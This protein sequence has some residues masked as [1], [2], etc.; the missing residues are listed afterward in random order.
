MAQAAQPAAAPP[1]FSVIG[2][3][4]G[5]GKTTLLNR[6]LAEPRA[7]RC[8]VLVNDFG[9]IAVD[10]ALIDARG[11]ET[12]AMQNG[13]ICC[14]I[15]GDLARAI[16]AALDLAPAHIVVEASGVAHPGR[17][18]AVARVSPELRPGRV[19][20]LADAGALR[21]QLND[22]WIADT[23]AAQL[24]AAD[25][26]LVSK[27][28][29]QP[30]REQA[31]VIDQ[32]A[33]DHP[34]AALSTTDEVQWADLLA[35]VDAD[36]CA[37]AAPAD[38]DSDSPDAPATATA[39][40]PDSHSPDMATD[41][42]APDSHTTAANIDAVPH[43]RFVARTLRADAPIDLRRLAAYLKSH[44]DIYR[45]K[46]WAIDPAD[47]K[48]KLLQAAGPRLAI[49]PYPAGNTVATTDTT[50]TGATGTTAATGNAGDGDADG[51]SG[52]GVGVG[53]DGVGDRVGVGGDGDGDGDH[54][55]ITTGILAILIGNQ[56]LPPPPQILRALTPD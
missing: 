49:T 27:L 41:A 10:A 14:S 18:A 36:A 54:P 13:C 34:A 35:A 11:G 56:N 40:A 2:G 19:F 33:R 47:G 3:F 53:N 48:L 38:V 22:A 50:V 21:A 8:A 16:A 37:D 25:H 31:A 30:P 9:D 28:D 26:I 4:L 1:P 43:A 12:I 29:A 44:P 46:G 52:D 45:L 24:R 15:G 6:L 51:V 7:P 5:A 55:A 20:V 42:A 23:V 32:L 17:I 39:A